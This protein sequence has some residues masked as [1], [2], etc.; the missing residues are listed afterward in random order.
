MKI[1]TL[2]REQLIRR[3]PNETFEFFADPHNLEALTPPW[4]KFTILSAPHE[5]EPGSKIR[6]RLKWH[7]VPLSWK[8]DIQ[9]WEPPFRFVD[10]QISGPYALWRH[11]HTFVPRGEA[12]LV[13]DHVEYAL[14]FGPLGVVAH[15]FMVRREVESIFDYR[16]HRLAEILDG[17]PV[18]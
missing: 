17:V 12:T 7:G 16:T 9:V 18:L 14:P 8:T 4:L 6:Y 2:R 5:L 3:S 13:Q 1:Y 10:M 15:R 11:T